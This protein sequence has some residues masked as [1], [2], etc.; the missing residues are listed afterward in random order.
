[1]LDSE[2]AETDSDGDTERDDDAEE[3]I[4]VGEAIGEGGRCVAMASW[5][6]LSREESR[7]I[8]GFRLQV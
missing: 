6:N 1:M 7:W 3:G 5:C 8:G 4:I 2:E